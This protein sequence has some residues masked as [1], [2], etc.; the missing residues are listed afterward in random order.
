MFKAKHLLAELARAVHVGGGIGAAHHQF[1]DGLRVGV[2]DVT[3]AHHD[4]VAQHGVAVGYLEDLVHLVGDEDEGHSLVLFQAFYDG[5]EMVYL[6][7]AE[8]GGGLIEDDEL[9]IDKERLG[10][11]KQ[12]LFCRIECGDEVGGVDLHAQPLEKFAGLFDHRALVGDAEFGDLLAHENV[13]VHLEVVEDIDLLVHEGD[14]RALGLLH[15][16][17]DKGFAVKDDFSP[18]TGVDAREDVHE[19]GLPRAVLAEER[20]HLALPDAEVHLVEHRDAEEG[21]LDAPHFKDIAHNFPLYLVLFL[22][23]WGGGSPAAVTR[24]GRCLRSNRSVVLSA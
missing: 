24:R 8:C 17:V 11:L 3:R 16:G 13:F 10:D 20:M 21:F 5:E 1:R 12:L 4:A 9:G 19:S 6:L 2:R 7:V 23:A 18:V 14:A 22:C 15:R